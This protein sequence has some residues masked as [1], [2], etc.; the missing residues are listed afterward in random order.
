MFVFNLFQSTVLLSFDWVWYVCIRQF[1]SGVL[2]RLIHNVRR[3]SKQTVSHHLKSANAEVTRHLDKEHRE[4]IVFGVT[5]GSFSGS[6][7]HC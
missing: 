3:N 7:S 1:V 4:Q 5:N 6:F 2:S